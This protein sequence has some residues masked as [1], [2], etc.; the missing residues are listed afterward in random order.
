MFI[1]A[2]VLQGMGAAN[3]VPSAMAL[4]A[5]H[6]PEGPTR[7][8]AFAVFRSFAVLGSIFGALLAGLVVSS[9]GWPW[10]FRASSITALLSY[11]AI[12]LTPPKNERPK[13]DFTGAAM[14]MFGVAGVV[15]YMSS[16]F[17]YGWTSLETL[18]TFIISVFLLATF[19]FVETKVSDPIMPLRIWKYRTFSASVILAFAQM[20][21]LQGIIFYTTMVMQEVFG[22]SVLKTA[23]G[24][25]IHPFLCM[26]IY[27][28]M[29]KV[30]PHL[31]LKPLI[32]FGTVIRCGATLLFSFADEH[33][34]YFFFIFLPYIIHAF[35]VSFTTLPN[36][37]MAI[38]EVN[39]CDQGLVS[40]IYSTGL[41]LGA[42]FGIAILNVISIA[43]NGNQEVAEHGNPALM[44]GYRNA[45]YGIIGFGIVSF[46]LALFFLP[47]DKPSIPAA[48]SRQEDEALETVGHRAPSI[49]DSISCG[50]ALTIMARSEKQAISEHDTKVEISRRW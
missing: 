34:S 28:V 45:F 50:S 1:F 12:P 31:R 2:R 15:Y 24:L 43:T 23:L 46:F 5:I 47:W 14:A 41:Q 33:S 32:L 42:P 17:D 44:K 30:M 9:L 37:I 38:R 10:I 13:I 21:M 27:I 6:Y 49:G 3:T 20:A 11:F 29:G 40:A 16:G 36:Q 7:S 18:P 26:L 39:N 25:I 48:V 8:K 35:G 19:V 22:W 4:V